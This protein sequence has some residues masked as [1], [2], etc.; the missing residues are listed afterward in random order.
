MAGER[1]GSAGAT[2]ARMTSGDAV[3]CENVWCGLEY[4]EYDGWGGL[5]PSC[6]TLLDEHVAVGHGHVV[7]ACPHCARVG[8]DVLRSPG[9]ERTETTVG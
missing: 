7:V 3:W 6:L 9:P 1:T 5:C 2:S 8:V 4:R